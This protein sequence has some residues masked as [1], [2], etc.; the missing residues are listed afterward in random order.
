MMDAMA[1]RRTATEIVDAV[2]DAAHEL[3]VER[4]PSAVS[5]REIA[6]RAGVNLGLIHRYVGS[7]DDVIDL[8]LKRHTARARETIESSEGDEELL[9]TVAETVVRR[10]STG[11]LIAG[12]LLDGADIASIKGDFPLMERMAAS[13][14]DLD[15]AIT[16]ALALGWEVFGPSLLSAIDAA[17]DAEET[18]A[19]LRDALAALAC[20]AEG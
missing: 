4:S 10:P 9:A 8:V 5:L 15:A 16:Y 6:A 12:L 13:G 20:P 17:P 1:R 19:A 7:K 14:R 2:T 11:R 3:F 18:E